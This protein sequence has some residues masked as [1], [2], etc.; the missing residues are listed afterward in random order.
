[1]GNVLE[2]MRKRRFVS[3]DGKYDAVVELVKREL[4][5]GP[6]SNEE[7][8]QRLG[9]EDKLVR[10]AIYRDLR[11][12]SGKSLVVW[13]RKSRRTLYGLFSS[14]PVSSRG[15]RYMPTF[16]PRGVRTDLFDRW[17]DCEATR[18]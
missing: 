15:S 3:R 12:A 9:I 7:L 4:A 6:L 11:R 18:R 8:S 1:M 16:T 10:N 2:D 5:N 14:R 13:G 17:A